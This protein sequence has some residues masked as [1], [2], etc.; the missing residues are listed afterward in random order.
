MFRFRNFNILI[1]CLL[2]SN[3]AEAASLGIGTHASPEVILGWDIDIRPDGLGL[4]DGEGSVSSGEP[5]YE[6]KCAGCHGLFG[7]GEGRWPVLAGGENTLDTMRPEKTVGSYWPYASTLWDYIYRAMPY[8]AP[9]SLTHEEVYSIAAY[10]LYLNDIVGD[11]FISNKKTFSQIKMPNVANF[12]VDDRPDVENVRCMKDC[13]NPA[14]FQIVTTIN[15]LTPT[16]HFKKDSGVAS[17]HSGSNVSVVQKSDAIKV[18][19]SPMANA[20]KPVYIKSCQTCHNTGIAGAP[21]LGDLVEWSSRLSQGIRILH[22]HAINGYQGGSG[23]MPAR[24]G[25]MSL[26]DDEVIN[27]VAYMVELSR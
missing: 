19:L 3:V 26:T 27:A 12:Y 6:S 17:S 21:K 25:N 7:E 18:A 11:D 10:V 13:A 1:A 20:G 16:S 8:T 2:M 9:Q 14:E 15:G 24:G 4:P 5:L 22:K 23:V